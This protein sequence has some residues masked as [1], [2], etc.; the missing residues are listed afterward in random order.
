M[1]DLGGREAF[2]SSSSEVKVD[3]AVRE[4]GGGVAVRRPR[5]LFASDGA[6]AAN[7]KRRRHQ[8]AGNEGVVWPPPLAPAETRQAGRNSTGRVSRLLLSDGNAPV[9]SLLTGLW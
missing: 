2:S 5:P 9:L 7:Q 8:E 6:E 3:A 1:G 4:R